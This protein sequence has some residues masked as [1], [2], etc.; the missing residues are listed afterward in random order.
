MIII[1]SGLEVV[2]KYRVVTLLVVAYCICIPA[3]FLDGY[4]SLG[5]Y[6]N[7]YHQPVIGI[8]AQSDL[9]LRKKVRAELGYSTT[10][11]HFWHDGMPKKDEITLSLG[12]HFRPEKLIDPYID[13]DGGFS[14][15][16]IEMDFGE[17]TLDSKNTSPLTSINVGI[18]STIL[19]RLP[20][21]FAEVGYS[22]FTPVDALNYPI[23]YKFGILY[24]VV[25]F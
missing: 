8:A 1:L 16:K 19:S 9:L 24:K 7:S 11:F 25:S 21:V 10:R 2:M 22:L 13:L 15:Y 12:W 20:S 6:H 17:S 4:A 5:V 14:T 3:S 23:T 18:E